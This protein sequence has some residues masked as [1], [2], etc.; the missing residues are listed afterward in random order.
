MSTNTKDGG[1]GGR[2]FLEDL[3]CFY[4]QKCGKR[5]LFP[6]KDNQSQETDTQKDDLQAAVNA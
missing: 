2:D 1:N 4:K 5:I 6:E 3:D